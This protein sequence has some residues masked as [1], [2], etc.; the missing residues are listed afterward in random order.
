MMP[1]AKMLDPMLG[2]DFHLIEPPGD[3][4]YDKYRAILRIDRDNAKA[5]TGLARISGRAKELFEQTVKDNPRKA[6]AHL[7]AIA[8]S[9][10]GGLPR[11]GAP[12]PRRRSSRPAN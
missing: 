9:D 3:C 12:T 2:I 7:D 8:Q 11:T 5:M 4:A 10:P 6:R 1:A